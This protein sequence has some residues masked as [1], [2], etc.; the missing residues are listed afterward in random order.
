MTKLTVYLQIG[1]T[2]DAPEA[3][4]IPLPAP[5]KGTTWDNP[6]KDTIPPGIKADNSSTELR[7]YGSATQAGRWS[8]RVWDSK[9]LSLWECDVVIGSKIKVFLLKDHPVAQNEIIISLGGV[10]Y[11]PWSE[12]DRNSK[13]IDN[14]APQGITYD[15]HTVGETSNPFKGTGGG[16]V[17]I[18]GS[19][20]KVGSSTLT[21]HSDSSMSVLAGG[22]TVSFDIVVEE[23]IEISPSDLTLPPA[24]S[25]DPYKTKITA[26][27]GSGPYKYQT[28]DKPSGLTLASDGTVSGVLTGDKLRRTRVEFWVGATDSASSGGH[29]DESEE[30]LNLNGWQHY[31]VNVEPKIILEPA[32]LPIEQAFVGKPLDFKITIKGGLE[33]YTYQIFDKEGT[34]ISSQPWLK[35]D[36]DISEGIVH[37]QGTPPQA[38]ICN[39]YVGAT[40]Y[41]GSGGHKTGWN[42]WCEYTLKIISEPSI[43]ISPTDTLLSG[44]LG[45][46]F[47][48]T[49]SASGG[50]KPYRYKI[51]NIS[52]DTPVPS[53]WLK[54]TDDSQTVTGG[55]L[56]GWPPHVGEY[57]F[58]VGAVDKNDR[59]AH[60]SGMNGWRSYTLKIENPATPVTPTPPPAIQIGGPSALPNGMLNRAYP[61]Q[62]IVAAGGSG[63]F[64]YKRSG[65]VPRGLDINPNTGV[66]SGIPKEVGDSFKFW[67][68]ATDSDGNGG[69]EHGMNGWHAE[70]TLVIKPELTVSFSGPTDGHVGQAYSGKIIVSG[71][72]PPYTYKVAGLPATLSR[73]GDGDAISGTLPDAGKFTFSITVSDALHYESVYSHLLSVKPA[74]SSENLVIRF[75]G[76]AYGRVNTPYTGT[77][78]VTGGLGP[79]EIKEQK[80]PTFLHWSK[81]GD[82]KSD[83]VSGTPKAPGLYELDVLVTDSAGHSAEKSWELE[84]A[85]APSDIE[86]SPFFIREAYVSPISSMDVAL[87][88]EGESIDPLSSPITHFGVSWAGHL[89]RDSSKISWVTATASN[90]GKRLFEVSTPV[91]Q[92][93]EPLYP[94]LCAQLENGTIVGEHFVFPSGDGLFKVIAKVAR[95]GSPV[96]SPEPVPLT[97]TGKLKKSSPISVKANEKFY[98]EFTVTPIVGLRRINVD[99]SLIGLTKQSDKIPLI[100]PADLADGDK[101]SLQRWNGANS[102]QVLA[103]SDIHIGK[104]FTAAFHLEVTTPGDCSLK[105]KLSDPEN[106]RTSLNS[107]FQDDVVY[108]IELHASA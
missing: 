51:W 46:Q 82:G 29:V 106:F 23:S 44:T 6:L 56:S 105:L 58:Y 67:L 89:E 16:Q 98:V 102:T 64:T 66:F 27:G 25:G 47:T 14:K 96:G 1:L 21:F 65:S 59:G 38:G 36:T 15:I 90:G 95:G 50:E 80:T 103:L 41:E 57:K 99:A 26:S 74:S 92:I 71:G 61:A 63:A 31:V 107:A 52:T 85:S 69:Q 100:S 22:R 39:F 86:K 10:S 9:E 91:S 101:D 94:V 13:P 12:F 62:T 54:I 77:L 32:S 81:G 34:A 19:A 55:V 88:V 76:E 40:D 84:V 70:Y 79:Y 48:Q 20:T 7:I 93:K 108:V 83:S 11:V 4:A 68:G 42:G 49:F 5:P 72:T 3:I 60:D 33:P 104:Y 53:D 18:W 8:I 24:V 78:S 28:K 17:R 30:I 73:N 35:L 45:Q 75:S 97:G 37:L 2:L 87:H 43:T